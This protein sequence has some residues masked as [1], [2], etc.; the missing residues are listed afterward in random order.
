MLHMLR[1]EIPRMEGMRRYRLFSVKYYQFITLNFIAGLIWTTGLWIVGVMP[2]GILPPLPRALNR[3]A[4]PATL[5]WTIVKH[6]ED[7]IQNLL[8]SEKYILSMLQVRVL[9]CTICQ[10]PCSLG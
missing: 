2:D 6:Q 9:I 4:K 7:L 8:Q 5:Q 10:I 1:A 3:L